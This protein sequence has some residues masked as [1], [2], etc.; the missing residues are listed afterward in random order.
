MKIL[1]AVQ[2]TGNGHITRA[3]ELIPHFEK[4]GDVDILVSGIQADLELPF[5]VKY[6][7]HG[8]S[9][10]FGKEG[11]LDLWR[12][13]WRLKSFK[14][15]K[16]IKKLPIQKYDLIISDFEPISCWA[17]L[18]AGKF[19]VGLSNQVA[20][21]HPLAPM[22]PKND[23]LGR[24]VL[25]HYAPISVG[26]GFHFKSLDQH[27]FT[28]IIR[29]AVRE[30]NNTDE[31]HY[32]VYLPSYSD[33]KIIKHLKKFSHITWEVFCKHSKKK[34]KEDNVSVYPINSERFL[35]S[36]ASASGVL[37]NAGFGVTS[38]ALFLGKKLLVVPMKNQFEQHCNA[39]ML[40]SM[41]VQ[42]IKKISKKHLVKLG[43]WLNSNEIILV[44]YPDQSAQIVEEIVLNH[45]GQ[46]ELVKLAKQNL[47]LYLHV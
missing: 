33:K 23:I 19:C 39:A 3:I 29:K 21:L 6:R 37:C 8:L 16:E 32:T 13:Y 36:M 38:E 26:Y 2:A 41:G 45:A 47:N 11:G 20:T 43:D 27:I 28:P 4:W 22:P 5:K 44:D 10:V 25:A 1:Y 34:Y 35:K 12:S 15:L 31:G 14:L 7:F 30:I 9:F 24:M 40:N 42:S 18:K 17:A 46:K